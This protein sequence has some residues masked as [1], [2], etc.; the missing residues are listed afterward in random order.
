MS[1]QVF[2]MMSNKEHEQIFFYRDDSVGLRSIIAIHDRTLGPALGGCRFWNYTNEH[3]ALVDVLRLSHGMTY[4][5]AMAGLPL[6]GGKA[7]IIGDHKNVNR[8][9]LFRSFGKFVHS[10]G[11]RYIT[12]EDVGTSVNDMTVVRQETPHVCGLAHAH[13]GGGDPSL[14][15]AIGA[16]YGMKACA[17]KAF[18]TDSL[19]GLKIIVQGLGHVGYPLAQHLAAEGAHLII[20][21]LDQ[22]Q[23]A[24][25]A[26]ELNAEVVGV[27]DIYDVKADIFCPN[28]LGAIFNDNTIDRLK[29]KIV[30]GAANNQLADYKK[31]GEAVFKKGIIYAPD[32]VINGGGLI[33]VAN[34]IK[35]YN[36]EKAVKDCQ[37]IFNTISMV[38]DLS[39]K[40]NIPTNVAADRIAESRIRG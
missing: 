27:N 20:A 37:N 18:G 25:V 39:E 23:A 11:G 8:E 32:Y 19:K 33:N 35:G 21:D 9:E 34:E 40:E 17:K 26:K 5:A 13:G 12:A 31:H 28:A 1:T 2:E 15:T 4:K 22:N 6:G 38:L 7:V 10:I 29:V 36:K 16:H 3:D 30:A 14:F 24:K